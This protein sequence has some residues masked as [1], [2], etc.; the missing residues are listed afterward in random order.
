MLDAYDPSRVSLVDGW[1]LGAVALDVAALG[2]STLGD[3][4]LDDMVPVA[5]KVVVIVAAKSLELLELG[6]SGTD[7]AA[8]GESF[9]KTYVKG[10]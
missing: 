9:E 7:I 4:A 3:V 8:K 6:M 10:S 1:R 5:T 2:D